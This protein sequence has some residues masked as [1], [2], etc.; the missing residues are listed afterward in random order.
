MSF[1]KGMISLEIMEV[2]AGNSHSNGKELL[3]QPKF[4]SQ[5]NEANEKEV[6]TSVFVNYGKDYWIMFFSL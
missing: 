4:A 6:K 1:Q 5:C 2:N 3:E